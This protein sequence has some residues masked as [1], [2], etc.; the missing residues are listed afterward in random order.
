MKA[1]PESARMERF[2]VYELHMLYHL[3]SKH[4]E[5][6]FARDAELS[7][8][9]FW[10]VHCL[11][12]CAHDARHSQNDIARMLFVTEATISR[13]LDTLVRR[14]ILKRSVEKQNKRKHDIRI[15]EK[16]EKWYQ[17]AQQ[18]LDDELRNI[19]S[20]LQMSERQPLLM[21]LQTITNTIHTI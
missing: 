12:S 17:K 14:G 9:Q 18:I 10:I 8:S 7:F 16:G 4:L 5:K 6:R 13:H 3:L 19:F 21:T 15:T 1:L 11:C 2:L 20:P